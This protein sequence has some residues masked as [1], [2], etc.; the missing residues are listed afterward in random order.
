MCGWVSIGQAIEVGLAR[1]E[2]YVPLGRRLGRPTSTVAR[3]VRRGGSRDCDQA[4]AAE[5]ASEVRAR[6]P[7]V[8]ELVADPTLARLVSE[9]LGERS[10]PGEVAARSVLDHPDEV[11]L[12][13]SHETI[14]SSLYLQGK[15]GLRSAAC[16][17]GSGRLRRRPR[18]RGEKA[19]RA[20]VR[21][22][23]AY[24]GPARRGRRPGLP[25]TSGG[26]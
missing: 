16:P 17:L 12:R 9:G 25:R 1:G 2:P 7:K 8:L 6:R 24:L 4:V 26:T 21:R 13:V 15:G 10:S 20:K 5:R 3:E 14:C 23:R 18:P 11:E 22:D 19:R